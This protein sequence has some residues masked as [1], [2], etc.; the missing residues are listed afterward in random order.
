MLLVDGNAALFHQMCCDHCNLE[1]QD[2]WNS[3]RAASDSSC[4]AAHLF[5]SL[6]SFVS[7]TDLLLKHYHCCCT[8]HLPYSTVGV[9]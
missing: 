6:S 9:V 8:V 2:L 3:R 1:K 5:S 7:L 4:V